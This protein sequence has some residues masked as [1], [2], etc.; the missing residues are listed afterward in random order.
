MDPEVAAAARPTIEEVAPDTGP[1][2]PTAA[3]RRVIV[4]GEASTF[5]WS[6]RFA[7]GNPEISV[8]ATTLDEVPRPG[9]LPGLPNLDIRGGVNATQLN[10]FAPGSFDTLVFNAPRPLRGSWYLRGSELMFDVLS[11][12]RRVLGP[13]GQARF[14]LTRGMAAAQ[15]YLDLTQGTPRFTPAPP[16]YL[17]PAQ[18]IPYLQDPYF[19]VPYTP[20]R[21]GGG[22]LY[23]DTL[24]NMNWIIFTVE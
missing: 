20:R 15:Y 10:Q 11:S 12:A 8:V 24:D 7:A 4:V 13:G 16:G 6:R 2:D 5:E 21:T 9:S 14:S 3:G 22:S 19:G 23:P 17:L 18:R 1:I